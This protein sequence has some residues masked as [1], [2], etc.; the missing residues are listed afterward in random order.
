M[1][2]QRGHRHRLQTISVIRQLLTEIVMVIP[3]ELR[4]HRQITL[5]TQRLLIV[6]GM[7]IQRVRI[8]RAQITLGIPILLTRIL[9][10]TQ[11]GLLQP[12]LITL[13]IRQRLIE[14]GMVIRKEHRLLQRII[15]AI[16]IP[17]N[18]VIIAIRQSGVGK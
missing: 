6:T 11:E 17:S 16:A 7:G 13:A 5:E 3:S 14:I 9:M 8:G 15:L 1:E 10:E 18:E 4:H 12:L 2:T